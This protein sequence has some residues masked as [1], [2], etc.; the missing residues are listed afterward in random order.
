MTRDIQGRSVCFSLSLIV[1]K[2][3][4]I[5]RAIAGVP[6]SSERMEMSS[7]RAKP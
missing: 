1:S 2:G 5:R 3:L 4:F 6:S 7:A